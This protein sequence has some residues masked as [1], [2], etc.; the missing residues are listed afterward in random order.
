MRSWSYDGTARI[1]TAVQASQTL[2]DGPGY[3]TVPQRATQYES[4]HGYIANP[5]A[6]AERGCIGSWKNAHEMQVT[7]FQQEGASFV[8]QIRSSSISTGTAPQSKCEYVQRSVMI[9]IHCDSSQRASLLF[10]HL[11]MQAFKTTPAHGDR[12]SDLHITRSNTHDRS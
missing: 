5:K 7:S 1:R 6:T 2:E 10:S 11:F 12:N 8:S 3:P 9:S 4:N